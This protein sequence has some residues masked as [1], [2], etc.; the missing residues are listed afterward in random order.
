LAIFYCKQTA[1]RGT[2]LF[3]GYHAQCNDGRIGFNTIYFPDLETG[4]GT[5]I[6]KRENGAARYTFRYRAGVHYIVV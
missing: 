6:A 4:T 3:I 1:S 5:G 2:T